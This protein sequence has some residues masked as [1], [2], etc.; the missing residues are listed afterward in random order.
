MKNLNRLCFVL[1]SYLLI[2]SQGFSGLECDFSFDFFSRTLCLLVTLFF[3]YIL[4]FCLHFAFI[5][6][7]NFCNFC[8]IHHDWTNDDD[9]DGFSS[10]KIV[11]FRNFESLLKFLIVSAH[12]NETFSFNFSV[13]VPLCSKSQPRGS[14]SWATFFFFSFLR[15]AKDVQLENLVDVKDFSTSF[16]CL[17]RVFPSHARKSNWFVKW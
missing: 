3:F 4:L 9:D 14:D 13:F 12:F 11:R 7:F 16:L 2:L 6:L 5:L 17:N 10:S 1:L 8:C 15:W